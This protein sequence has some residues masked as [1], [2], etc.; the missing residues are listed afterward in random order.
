M[1]HERGRAC[2]RSSSRCGRSFDKSEAHIDLILDRRLILDTNVLIRHWNRSRPKQLDQATTEDAVAWAQKL[3]Q[4]TRTKATVTPV[5]VEFVCGVLG[6]HEMEL[7]RAF[8]SQFV[9]ADDGHIT[10]E[11]WAH[12]RRLAERVPHETRSRQLGDCLIKAIADRLRYAVETFDLGM[13]RTKSEK[14]TSKRKGT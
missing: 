10:E 11:D 7:A 4:V 6:R 1:W 13:P 2:S 8:L 5:A 3:I 9:L 12:A 14:R